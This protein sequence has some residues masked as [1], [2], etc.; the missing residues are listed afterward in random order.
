MRKSNIVIMILVPLIAITTNVSAYNQ[1]TG[2]I[3]HFRVF[4]AGL[5]QIFIDNPRDASAPWN[6]DYD[7]VRLADTEEELNK[8]LMSLALVAFTA[9]HTIRF[10]VHDQLSDACKIDYI[11]ILE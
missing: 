4:E 11:T 2:E 7:A 1:V 6:C 8:S 5:I 10:G 9:K 3:K